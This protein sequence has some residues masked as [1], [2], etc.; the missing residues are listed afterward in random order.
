[1]KEIK[2]VNYHGTHGIV[3]I[4]RFTVGRDDQTD[5]VMINLRLRLF[6]K[7]KNY[8]SGFEKDYP[9]I[10]FAQIF[11]EVFIKDDFDKSDGIQILENYLNGEIT[12]DNIITVGDNLND[13]NLLQDYNGY[14]MLTS[15]PRMYGKGLKTTREVHTLIKKI[16]R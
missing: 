8:I 12:R 14:K 11:N 3:D 13:L 7:L 16:N 15:Y 1:M 5:I 2:E 9:N 4:D 10:K 6:K